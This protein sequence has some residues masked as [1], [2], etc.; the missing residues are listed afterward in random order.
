M[1]DG[2]EYHFI[3]HTADIMFQ[4]S[5]KNIEKAFENSARALKEVMFSGVKIEDKIKKKFKIEAKDESGLLYRFLEH[6]LY[7]LDAESFIFNKV[8]VK[9][10]KKEFE[11]EAEAWGDLRGD[12]NFTN[13]VKA[14]TYNS[15]FVK[16]EKGK[17]IV[18]VVLDV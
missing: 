4:A 18:Q 8:K 7:L 10:N 16:E 3:D 1:K 13:D 14:I 5:G 15:M 6:F 11:L 9:I 2:K 17:T 12:Y